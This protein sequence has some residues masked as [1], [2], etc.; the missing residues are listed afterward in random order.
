MAPNTQARLTQAPSPSSA[1]PSDRPAAQ[2]IAGRHRRQQVQR[3][4]PAAARRP[5]TARPRPAPASRARCA[6]STH[7][8][9]RGDGAG[10]R[11]AGSRSPSCPRTGRRR[12]RPA[13]ASIEVHGGA[14]VVD[15]RCSITPSIGSAV[16]RRSTARA[17]SCASCRRSRPARR[18]RMPARREVD[19]LGVVLAV[20]ARR[21]QVRHVHRRA[22]A[23]GRE[24]LAPSRR[25]ACAAGICLCSSRI[26]WR[27]RWICFCRAMWLSARLAYW[28]SFCRAHHLPDR[29][30]LGRRSGARR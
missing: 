3:A 9:D 10:A 19:V 11:R 23:P 6:C 18:A 27:S 7:L 25:S 24:L 26:T 28:M 13:L 22:A 12:R 2:R 15:Q 8:V 30:R 21:E 14:S 29:L 1:P 5:P 16:R 4:A 20:D 17:R